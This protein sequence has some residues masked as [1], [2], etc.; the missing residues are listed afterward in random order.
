MQ[1]GWGL[2]YL[3][4]QSTEVKLSPHRSLIHHLEENC[5]LIR[6]FGRQCIT[7]DQSKGGQA[8]V[9]FRASQCARLKH[10]TQSIALLLKLPVWGNPHTYPHWEAYNSWHG[11]PSMLWKA[12]V[13]KLLCIKRLEWYHGWKRHMLPHGALYQEN[14][15]SAHLSYH[16]IA[17]IKHL[18]QSNFRRTGL[19]WL[20]VQKYSSP[21]WGS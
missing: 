8:W 19:P 15:D 13:E 21:C 20:Q 1:I 4:S 2:E 9:E 5:K 17:I 11:T 6:K 14:N 7:S 16:L 3:R 12:K 10:I 18:S